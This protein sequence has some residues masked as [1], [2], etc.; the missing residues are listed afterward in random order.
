M[1]NAQ[2]VS[3]VGIDKKNVAVLAIADVVKKESKELILSLKKLGIK[4]YMMTGDN[5]QTAQSIANEIG[6]DEVMAQVT[7]EQKAIKVK[8]LQDQSVNNIVA[9]VGDGINDAPALAQAH[10]GI[11]MGT[12]TDVAI[13]TGDIVLVGGSVQKVVEAIQV[14]KDTLK[15]IKQNLFWAFGYNIIGIPIAAG[16]LYPFYG[17]LLSPIIASMAMALSSVSV[18][19]NSLRLKK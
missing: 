16:I 15:T 6:L 14:S 17:I 5:L 1:N 8:E 2:T 9:M 3:F 4:T 12:G 18:V 19:S 11:A 7:P 10:I 13:E